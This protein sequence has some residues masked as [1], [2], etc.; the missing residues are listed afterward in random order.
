MSTTALERPALTVPRLPSLS[1]LLPAAPTRSSAGARP[2][3]RVR[4]VPARRPARPLSADLV[5]AHR[6]A[7]PA[8]RTRPTA[9]AR[10]C[11][12]VTPLRLTRRGRL[13]ITCTAA[14][15]LTGAVLVVA[16]V[17]GGPSAAAGSSSGPAPAVVTVLPGQTLSQIAGDWAPDDDWR[18]TA[19]EIVELNELTTQAVQAGQQLALP[20]RS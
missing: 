20:A 5:V 4:W 12:A 18:E 10:P 19:A 2:A 14:T 17:V 8:R 1:V 15:V 6:T 16:S 9:A 7:A 3:A 11:R 13:V